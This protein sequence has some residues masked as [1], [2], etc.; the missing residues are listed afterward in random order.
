MSIAATAE[1]AAHEPLVVVFNEHDD[2]REAFRVGQRQLALV[3]ALASALD[4]GDLDL[5]QPGV[6]ADEQAQLRFAAPLYFAAALESARLLPALELFAALW[7]SGGL[8][9]DLGPVGP[10]LVRFTREKDSRLAPEERAALFGRIFGTPDGPD[11]AAPGGRNEAFEP[12]LTDAAAAVVDAWEWSQG[13]ALAP[14]SAV[15]LRTAALR[16][17]D[18]LSGRMGG[19]AAFAAAELM[20][21]LRFAISVFR[22]P[23]VQHAVAAN[24][25]WSAVRIIMQQYS[26]EA[27]DVAPFVAKAQAGQA[28]L[29]WL[30]DSA[31]ALIAGAT[32]P[33]DEA[34]VGH[35]IRWIDAARTPE[36]Q[37]TTGVYGFRR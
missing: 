2:L 3:E 4:L 8:G 24:S 18:S 16:V 7:S 31:A 5:P 11:Y 29:A 6:T 32:V 26:H 23:V 9:I 12:A 22:M 28:L 19:I 17:L 30:A 25:L 20:E 1:R 13:R 37:R 10:Q 14:A 21:Q 15:R 35:A 33:I 36:P 27:V 34:L